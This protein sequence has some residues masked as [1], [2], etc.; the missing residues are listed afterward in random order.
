MSI[1][2]QVKSSYKW[3][4]STAVRCCSALLLDLCPKVLCP[5]S[6]KILSGFWQATLD[7]FGGQMRGSK[8]HVGPRLGPSLAILG[9]VKV[10]G[11]YSSA[12]GGKVG[13]SWG[14]VGLSGGHVEAKLG[15]VMSCWSYTSDFGKL[16]AS[17]T[18]KLSGG[19]RALVKSQV[20][21]HQVMLP[22]LLA[23]KK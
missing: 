15:Y 22:K 14:Q 3:I 11:S 13:G 16:I 9:P 8:Q 20:P 7:P 23:H 21:A 4:L 6:T 2:Q 5:R 18:H 17:Y 19:H 10:S 12:S 1:K